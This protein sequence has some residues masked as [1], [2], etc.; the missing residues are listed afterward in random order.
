MSEPTDLRTRKRLATRRTISQAAD[1]L[2]REKGFDNVTVDEIAA[3]AEVGRMTVFNYFARKEDMFFDRDEEG[4]AL[5]RDALG[6]RDPEVSPIETLRRRVHRLVAE[7]APFVQFST[8]SRD[9]VQTVDQSHTLKARAREIRDE[10][11]QVAAVALADSVG[12]AGDDAEARLAAGLVLATWTLAFIEAHR[13]YQRT[14][15]A[16]AATGVFLGLVDRG[17]QGARAALVDTPYA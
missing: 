2:F 5:I 4:R 15:D 13:A 3:A 1:R 11:A 8:N 12:R 17:S 10:L 14:G 9:F 7:A 6:A 16:A